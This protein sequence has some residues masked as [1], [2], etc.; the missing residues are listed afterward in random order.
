MVKAK[1][2][3]FV[4]GGGGRARPLFLFSL[5][6]ALV[7]FLASYFREDG[8]RNVIHSDHRLQSRKEDLKKIEEENAELREKIKS[9]KEGS[10]LMEKYAREKLFMVKDDEMVFRF[11]ESPAPPPPGK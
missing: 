11:Y 1:V 8:I 9:I 10:Y 2:L 6:F 5:L 7:V 3:E 4:K